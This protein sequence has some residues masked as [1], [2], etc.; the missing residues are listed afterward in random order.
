MRYIFVLI[1]LLFSLLGYTQ[2]NHPSD[3]KYELT[4]E[5]KKMLIM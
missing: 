1:A 3:F 2:N 4:D 5:L